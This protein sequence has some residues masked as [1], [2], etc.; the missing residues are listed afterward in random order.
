MYAYYP[1]YNSNFFLQ[2][3][4]QTPIYLASCNPNQPLETPFSEIA[5]K[6]NELKKQ[7]EKLLAEYN[8][9]LQYLQQRGSL[10]F[11]NRCPKKNVV[12]RKDEEI[13]K[14]Y[15][16]DFD[17]CKKEYASKIALNLHIKNKHRKGVFD[18]A[19]IETVRFKEM[20][21]KNNERSGE[22]KEYK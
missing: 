20:K 17:N 7:Y 13:Q 1:S 3:L 15:P 9:A 18:E 11:Q 2:K 12:R 16:C 4:V 22:S 5:L 21:N 14:N 6:Y 8:I 19:Q 10:N